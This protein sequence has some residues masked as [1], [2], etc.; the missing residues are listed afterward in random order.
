MDIIVVMC[1]KMHKITD[2]VTLMEIR[3]LLSAFFFTPQTLQCMTIIILLIQ[4]NIEKEDIIK[5]HIPVLLKPI[6]KITCMI[7]YLLQDAWQWHKAVPGE[8]QTVH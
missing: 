8:V 6:H 7:T 3:F 5:N 2:V 4:K 1:L